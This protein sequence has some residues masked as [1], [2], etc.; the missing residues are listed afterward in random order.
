MGYKPST[1]IISLTEV[2]KLYKNKLQFMV[3]SGAMIKNGM[4]IYNYM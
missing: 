2:S 3:I 1:I 4:Y